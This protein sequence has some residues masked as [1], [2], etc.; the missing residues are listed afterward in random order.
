M[1]SQQEREQVRLPQLVRLGTLKPM[2]HRPWLLPHRC[3]SLHHTFGV[4]HSTYGRLR[5][6]DPQKTL[7]Q[8]AHPSRPGMGLLRFGCQDRFPMRLRMISCV[9]GARR[10]HTGL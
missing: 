9:G 7:H 8:V 4:Q 1:S 10:P 5:S 3:P 2:G 6:A